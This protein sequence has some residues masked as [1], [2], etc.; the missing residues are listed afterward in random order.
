MTTV[1][2][3]AFEPY[4]RWQTNASWLTLVELTQALPRE[5]SITT[6]LYPVDFAAVK[7]RL[8][9]DL[10]AN[11]D[12]AIHLGQAPGSGRVQLEAVGINIGGSSHQSPDQFLP[13]SDDG[14]VAYRSPLPL[15]AW[16]VKLREA[17]IPAQVS[18]HAGTYLCNATLYWTCYLTERLSIR[19]QAAFVHLPLDV[20]QVVGEPHGMPSLPTSLATKALRLIL[21]ELP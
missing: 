1:L 9:K 2:L 3:T 7:Q 11:Y 16:A 6:R 8:A 21:E 20:S 4:D 18:Y 5:P 14:P 13:L 10:A 17:G 12:F 15:P 19:T